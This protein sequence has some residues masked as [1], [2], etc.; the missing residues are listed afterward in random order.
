MFALG[1]TDSLQEAQGIFRKEFLARPELLEKQCLFV[2]DA[3]NAVAAT[4]SVWPGN[5]FGR[6]LLRVHY[7]ACAE[8]YQGHGLAKALLSVLLDTVRALDYRDMLYLTSQTWSYKALGL[9][10]K[11]GFEP[12]LGEKPANWK[13]QSGDFAQETQDAWALINSKWRIPDPC[14]LIPE[15]RS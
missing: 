1:Q 14:F 3:D 12:Y 5:H 2:L 6:E 7:V 10:A 8:K 9:Y 11:F 4:A 15:M 13:A